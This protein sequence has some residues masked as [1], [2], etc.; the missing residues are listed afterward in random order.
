MINMY[1]CPNK[2][3]NDKNDI[4]KNGSYPR[5]SDSKLIQ[6]FIC[7]TCGK[8]FSNATYSKAFNQKKRRLNPL[9]YRLLC[10]GVSQRR[11]A[12][13]LSCNIKTVARKL[14]FLNQLYDFT[15]N[16][17]YSEITEIQFDEMESWEH[18]KLNPLSILVVVE[19]KTRKI[20]DLKV[21]RM[22]AK[23]LLRDRSLK[24]YGKIKDKRPEMFRASFGNLSKLLR[25]QLQI[26]S[27]ESPRYKKWVDHFF[28]ESEYTQYK[29]RRGCVVGQGELK[30]GGKDPLFSLNHTCAMIRANVNR[31]FRRT[32][33]TTK[34]FESLQMHLNLYAN[35]HN[36]VLTN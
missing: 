9:I 11:I 17:N 22:P 29:G 18:S 2:S 13:L 6:R 10:S 23:G 7:N 24:K 5:K 4:V 1:A 35:Y 16:L 28:E 3:C 25:S 36:T 34:R 8:Q 33:C 26:E 20:L 14:I 27:D 30:R 15:S 31:L 21:F 19:K 32:W 12:L